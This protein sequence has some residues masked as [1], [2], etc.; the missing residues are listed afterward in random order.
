MRQGCP[1]SPTL[2]GVFIDDLDD[3]WEKINEGGTVIGKKKIFGLKFADDVA[4]VADAAEGLQKMLDDLQRK[5]EWK[6][7]QRRRK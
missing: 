6:C 7:T 4:M 3:R 2:F 1:L 5:M